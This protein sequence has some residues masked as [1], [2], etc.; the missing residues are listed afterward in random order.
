MQ[1]SLIPWLSGRKE[2][3]YF[4]ASRDI[5]CTEP[6]LLKSVADVEDN[7][8]AFRTRVTSLKNAVQSA[9]NHITGGQISIVTDVDADTDTDD[10]GYLTCS[11]FLEG[12][13]F[14]L[15]IFY[16]CS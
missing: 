10:E 6:K 2:G 13:L 4:D 15:F 3:I 9:L 14:F 5:N 7:L 12:L 8:L 11:L 1:H 16:C